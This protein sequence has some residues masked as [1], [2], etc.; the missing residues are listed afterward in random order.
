MDSGAEEIK[1]RS[2]MQL[3]SFTKYP[4]LILM[5]AVGTG[6]IALQVLEE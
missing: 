2:L 1:E 4:D 6:Y 3:G 5:M